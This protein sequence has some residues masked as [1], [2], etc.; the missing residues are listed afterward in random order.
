MTGVLHKVLPL[1]GGSRQ[2]VG[3]CVRVHVCVCGSEC[4]MK[5]P[6]MLHRSPRVLRL[7]SLRVRTGAPLG[8]LGRAGPIGQLSDAARTLRPCSGVP[9][10]S[11]LWQRIFINRAFKRGPCVVTLSPAHSQWPTAR[12]CVPSAEGWAW[13]PVFLL[14]RAPAFGSLTCS[15]C[16]ITAIDT[17]WLV[18]FSGPELGLPCSLPH[19]AGS[20]LA[21]LTV[22]TL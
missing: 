22:P 4:T 3:V 12:T 10:R 2:W 14:R 1:F 7:T 17:V 20:C 6:S 9:E 5:R 13:A 18:W 19:P 8:T 15:I 21:D 16:V 11:N